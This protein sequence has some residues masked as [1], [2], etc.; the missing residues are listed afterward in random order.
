MIVSA[1][2]SV[3]RRTGGRLS[4]DAFAARLRVRFA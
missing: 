1:P 4:R 2:D 3:K